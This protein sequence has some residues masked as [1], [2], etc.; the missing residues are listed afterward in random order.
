[1]T[2]LPHL[3]CKSYEDISEQD[4]AIVCDEFLVLPPPDMVEGTKSENSNLS[5]TRRKTVETMKRKTAEK[6][7]APT[8]L[9]HDPNAPAN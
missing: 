9:S 4:K 6:P 1:M 7:T 8:P 2:W 5:R 3:W